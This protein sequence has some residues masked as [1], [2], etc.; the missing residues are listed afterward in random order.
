[1]PERPAA[2]RIFNAFSAKAPQCEN[3]KDFA[4]TKSYYRNV[5]KINFFLKL[6]KKGLQKLISRFNTFFFS[7]FPHCDA[8]TYYSHNLKLLATFMAKKV[9]N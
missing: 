1:M 5:N 7:S 8:S 9:P 6:E 2:V 4:L 3:K